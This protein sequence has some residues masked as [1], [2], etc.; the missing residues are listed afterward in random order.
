MTGESNDLLIN[1]S[2]LGTEGPFLA[3]MVAR[4]ASRHKLHLSCVVIG[5]SRH[6]GLLWRCEFS[7]D[8]EVTSLTPVIESLEVVILAWRWRLNIGHGIN[9]CSLKHSIELI[10]RRLQEIRTLMIPVTW[11][12]ATET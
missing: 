1:A 8:G 10:C 12:L 3:T 4:T 5:W 2:G 11:S 9:R 7:T 6:Q